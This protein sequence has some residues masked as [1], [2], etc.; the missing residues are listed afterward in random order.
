MGTILPYNPWA[1]SGHNFSGQSLAQSGHNSSVQSLGTIWAQFFWTIDRMEKHSSPYTAFHHVPSSSFSLCSIF[2]LP[3]RSIFQPAE[4][5]MFHLAT[6]R[7][8]KVTPGGDCTTCRPPSSWQL[9]AR[10]STIL[11]HPAYCV[12]CVSGTTLG[13]AQQGIRAGV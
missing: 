3:C 1:Q 2:K 9:L 4:W 5:T 8:H 13:L 7:Q 10:C 11:G 6:L 12:D